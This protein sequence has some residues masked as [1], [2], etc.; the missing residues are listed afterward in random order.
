M[1]RFI[2]K[3]LLIALLIVFLVSIFAFSLM[4]ILPGD[5]ARISLGMDASQEDV[6]ALRE[7][8]NLDKPLVQQ[9]YLWIAGMARGDF[10]DSIVYNRP[11][12]DIIL[13]KLPKTLSIGVPSLII[14]VTLGI[15]FGVICAIKR[16]KFIDQVLTFFS[17]VGIGTPQF[18]IGILGIY[19][20]GM[21]LR[22]LPIQGYVA[23]SDNFGDYI[24]HAIMPVFCMSL[25]MIASVAR[26][27][28]SNML[29]VINQDYIRTARA[30][31]I[32]ERSVIYKHSLRNTLIPIITIVAMQVRNVIG[33]SL[34]IENVFNIA[35][36]GALLNVAVTN[37]DYLIVQTCTLIISLVTVICNLIV[38]ILYGVVNPQIRINGGN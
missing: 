36:I 18:W 1:A 37:R 24:R 9:Y 15:V 23:P 21:R 35:G 7:K 28:R 19:L 22:I 4:H 8:M 16:G 14:S 5:P 10:G 26:Q 20:F 11:V 13:E 33:G 32:S 29:D 31:G 3:R 6:D 25:S 30:N 2:I 17:T 27:T 34:I 12:K 38:D